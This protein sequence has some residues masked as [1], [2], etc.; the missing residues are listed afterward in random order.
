MKKSF[1]K[2]CKCGKVT[3]FRY[4]SELKKAIRLS[5]K[6]LSCSAKERFSIPENN[7]MFGRHHTEEGR[8]HISEALIGR[9]LT[10]EQCVKWSEVKKAYWLNNSEQRSRYSQRQTGEG[11]TFYGKR[12][13][14]KTKKVLSSKCSPYLK[15]GMPVDRGATEYFHQ[16]NC[17]NGTHIEHPNIFVEGVNKYLDGYDPITHTAYE[18]D[19]KYHNRCYQKKADL[20]RQTKIISHYETIGNPLKAF[21]RINATGVGPLAAKKVYPL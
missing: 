6:C 12:H 17:F 2:V 5:D 20:V 11:N 15:D 18:F 10:P 8:K 1:L 7:P 3:A 4:N 16:H 14:D 13:T 19:T 9:T 21:V